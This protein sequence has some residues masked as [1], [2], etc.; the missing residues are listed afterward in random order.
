MSGSI[1]VDIPALDIQAH[2]IEIVVMLY[3]YVGMGNL[4]RMGYARLDRWVDESGDGGVMNEICSRVAE[5]DSLKGIARSVG[6]PYSV[7]WNYLQEGDRMELY[8]QAKE[9]AAESLADEVLEVADTSEVVRDRVDAR[10]WLASKWGKRTYG[11]KQDGDAKVGIT[12]IV[13]RDGVS[14]GTG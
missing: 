7:I 3:Y 8:R 14:Y 13:Q 12:V 9:A 5:G 10:K 6:M 1:G 4:V 11:D 2:P